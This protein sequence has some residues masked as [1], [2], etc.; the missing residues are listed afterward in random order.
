MDLSKVNNVYFLGIGGIGMSALARY[1][2][3]RGAKVSGYDKTSTPL[4]TALQNEGISVHFS[5][6][7]NLIPG[8]PELV[9]YTPAVPKTL[10]EYIH[11]EEAGIPI[12]KRAAVL[13]LLS[14][15]YNTIAV[16]GTHGKTTV[17]TMCAH[18]L[19]QSQVHC[20]A[21]LGGISKNYESN[22]LESSDSGWLVTEADEFDRSFLQLYPTTAVITSM[23]ADHLDI[24]NDHQNLKNNFSQF[25]AQVDK[26]GNLIHKKDLP[27]EPPKGIN[28]FNYALEEQ[29]DYYATDIKL[30]GLFYNFTIH[31][32][33]GAIENC[34]LGVPGL[35]NIE[36]AIAATAAA[37]L[38]GASDDEIREGL[39][40][41]KGIKRR[42]DIHIHTETLT[43]MDDYAHHPEEIRSLVKSVRDMFEGK[44]I[45]GI[46]Q[47]H[48]F[49]RTRDFADGFGES[50]SLLDEVILLPIYPARELPIPG[51]DSEML[52]DFIQHDH[53]SLIEKS[54]FP[55]VLD[56][57]TF[58]VLLTIG[59][60]DIDQLVDPIE[61]YLINRKHEM[62]K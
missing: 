31:T 5:D 40:T 8:Y 9:I 27:L 57:Y 59:A 3:N 43:Y 18:I 22:L 14:K 44:K 21:F 2:H 52:L 53:K 25:A 26:G 54:R 60:G 35:V 50:L 42:L 56:N 34:T 6:N 7:P 10:K 28:T 13:G 45:L 15:N 55:K 47:P 16:A 17:S 39:K 1:F 23:D 46:F 37:Q 24:Y 36:N 48:L 49:S 11:L 30:D 20:R 29:A 32:P 12:L 4:T 62:L 61:N 58:D 19:Y 51:V 33:Q 38:A 41:F